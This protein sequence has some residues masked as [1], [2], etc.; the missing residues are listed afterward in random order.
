MAYLYH[1][2][3][4]AT[5]RKQK[6]AQSQGLYQPRPEAGVLSYDQLTDEQR[7]SADLLHKLLVGMLDEGPA[8]SRSGGR[9]QDG[10]DFLP[11][12]YK[13]RD[14]RVCMIDGGRGSGKT[15]LLVSLLNAWNAALRNQSIGLDDKFKAWTEPHGR[16]IPV[17]NLELHPLPDTTRLLVHITNQ[18]GRV[19][20]SLE[21]TRPGAKRLEAAPW[22]LSIEDER[23]SRRCWKRLQRCVISGWDSN[24]PQRKGQLD[25]DAYLLEQEQAVQDQMDLSSCFSAFMDAL[26]DEFRAVHGTADRHVLFIITVDDADMNPHR[27]V[28]LL[29]LLRLLWHPRLA[30]VLTGESELFLRTLR[31]HLLGVLHQPLRGMHL[32]ADNN[33]E[34]TGVAAR[35]ARQIYDK[36]IPP[37]HR[38]QLP[39]LE[40]S[41][42]FAHRSVDV[43]AALKKIFIYDER[44]ELSIGSYFETDSQLCEALPERLRGL[45]DLRQQIERWSEQKKYSTPHAANE[46]VR[47]L[48]IDAIENHA[49]TLQQAIRGCITVE[50][51]DA[52]CV[53]LSGVAAGPAWGTVPHKQWVA[54]NLPASDSIQVAIQ[55]LSRLDLVLAGGQRLPG[56][57][58][59]ALR[60][61]TN[62]AADQPGGQLRADPSSLTGFEPLFA[63]ADHLAVGVQFA[64]PLP[65]RL[66][67]LELAVLSS[68]WNAAL[69]FLSPSSKRRASEDEQDSLARCFLRLILLTMK[70]SRAVTPGEE[71]TWDELAEQT[72]RLATRPLGLSPR[73]LAGSRWAARGAWLL[74]APESGLAPNSAGKWL[75]ALFSN[76][77]VN[78]D[79][80]GDMLLNIIE[81]R[82]R[83]ANFA[84]GGALTVSDLDNPVVR[85]VDPILQVI[86][87]VAGNDHPWVKKFGK[88]PIKEG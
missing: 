19:V 82:R 24:I 60:L 49:P 81:E 71:W 86:D 13:K 78:P 54:K 51:G 59:A 88:H 5:P 45:L 32:G 20:D 52:L 79:R 34:R 1:H 37:G 63:F 35:L 8:G 83:R 42:R 84:L 77:R 6:A 87:G 58:T 74:A 57:V 69:V 18:L 48:W 30:F 22:Q 62:V 11:V 50:D 44:P 27:S 43:S 7:Q 23:S 15:A 41:Q 80:K 36:I 75:D 68:R 31:E 3:R 53:D 28:E 85:R 4:V 33:E 17:Y 12:V 39:S 2:V 76:N 40:P 65:L 25:P 38:A 10:L 66:S 29:D 16:F 67:F 14:N 55:S 26:D 47:R 70:D 9:S 46:V 56:P 21:G 61:A 72:M 73:M 64:W